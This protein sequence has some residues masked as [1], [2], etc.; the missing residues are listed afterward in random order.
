MIQST[1]RIWLVSLFQNV[2]IFHMLRIASRRHFDNDPHLTTSSTASKH[3]RRRV[4]SQFP[5]HASR[6]ETQVSETKCQ[7]I[8]HGGS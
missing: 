5:T 8:T 4:C 7:G 1:K 2:T 3:S 6:Q